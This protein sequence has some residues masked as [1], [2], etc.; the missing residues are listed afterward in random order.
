MGQQAQRILKSS[1]AEYLHRIGD[2][3]KG[4]SGMTNSSAAEIA[5][6]IE[7]KAYELWA[8]EGRKDG[9]D[10]KYWCRATQIVTDDATGLDDEPTGEKNPDTVPVD[11]SSP[12]GKVL[13]TAFSGENLEPQEV[14]EITLASFQSATPSVVASTPEMGSLRGCVDGFG[15]NW[16]D[17]WAQDESHPDQ[18][19]TLDIT[20]DDRFVTRITANLYRGDLETAGLGN[21]KHGFRAFL[22]DSLGGDIRVFR[23][24]DRVEVP[25]G[26][27]AIDGYKAAEGEL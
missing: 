25:R 11:I 7:V 15:S 14:S 27:H 26:Q 6:K 22:G 17:G 12:S 4:D 2:A 10:Q 18:P 19:V 20:V 8:A 21:G 16:V 3:R 1:M 9:C 24:A 13:E 5:K 23:S